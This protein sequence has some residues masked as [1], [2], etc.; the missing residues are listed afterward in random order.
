[1]TGYILGYPKRK[2]QTF[3]NIAQY[4]NIQNAANATSDNCTVYAPTLTLAK[5]RLANLQLNY[6]IPKNEDFERQ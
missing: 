1:M 4:D 2:E 6:F 3:V 5:I